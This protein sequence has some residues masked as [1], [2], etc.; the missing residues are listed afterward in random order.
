MSYKLRFKRDAKKEWDKLDHNIKL[1]FLKKLEERLRNPHVKGAR[2]RQLKGCYKIKL[3]RARY[4]LVY[5]VRDD[6]LVVS[7]IAIGKRDK[8]RAYRLAMKRLN[9]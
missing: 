7:I 2:L 6:E 5:Q 4:R 9:I 1:V 3:R 8:N